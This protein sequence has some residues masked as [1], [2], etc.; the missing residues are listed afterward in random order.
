MNHWFNSTFSSFTNG[1]A[2]LLM[3]VSADFALRA[4]KYVI[5]IWEGKI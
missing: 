4:C 5:K 3:I 1:D 2:V